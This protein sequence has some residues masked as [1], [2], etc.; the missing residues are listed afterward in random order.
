MMTRKWKKSKYSAGGA[1]CVEARL[2]EAGQ[3]QFRDTKIKN[4]PIVTASGEAW[5][6]LLK[7]VTPDK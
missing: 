6:H 5:G 3:V 2:N 4:S 7:F 1:N